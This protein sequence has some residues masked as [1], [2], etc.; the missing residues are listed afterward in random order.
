MIFPDERQRVPTP[1]FSDETL[2]GLKKRSY[3]PA[4][5]DL[6]AFP[7]FNFSF[8]RPPGWEIGPP[9]M[10]P[11]LALPMPALASFARKDPLALVELCAFDAPHDCLPG[12][13][14]DTSLGGFRLS[15]RSEGPLQD[16]WYADRMGR[17]GQGY[18]IL[19]AHRKG[20]NIF[21]F[22]C[23][24]P[25]TSLAAVRDEVAT[26]I[27]TFALRNKAEKRYADRW[28]K[29]IEPGMQLAFAVPA[30]AKQT[31]MKVGVESS[32]RI[33][34]GQVSIT[35]RPVLSSEIGM[36]VME[37]V[38][39]RELMQQEIYIGSARVGDLPASPTGIFSGN[40]SIRLYDSQL[41]SPRARET[42]MLVG[43][44]KDGGGVRVVGTY[45]TRR[46]HEEAWMRARFALVQIAATLR[47]A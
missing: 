29:Y 3:K 22:L 7:Q 21:V 46:T 35:V 47:A 12:D 38:L 42:L 25:L 14:L 6:T 39:K 30:T 9:V 45:P 43:K 10:S 40:V 1:V 33:G 20:K 28:C 23:A 13:F 26:L 11:N 19:A 8:L 41:S 44:R 36:E 5:V 17:D 2:A 34:T 37:S 32:W 31:P 16:G 4:Y 24:M 27:G 18:A 15:H